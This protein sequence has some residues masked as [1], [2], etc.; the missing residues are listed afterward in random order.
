MVLDRQIRF[1]CFEMVPCWAPSG[2]CVST[3]VR[4][5][6]EGA[7]RFCPKNR[8]S[9]ACIECVLPLV[10]IHPTTHG[11]GFRPICRQLVWTDA[12]LFACPFRSGEEPWLNCLPHIF[13]RLTDPRRRFTWA[14]KVGRN[15]V[16]TKS[17]P[18]QCQV[19]SSP[20]G[21]LEEATAAN[22]TATKQHGCNMP[23]QLQ[24]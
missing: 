17:Q 21:W 24:L 3:I 6:R 18:Q 4:R 8:R 15:I 12:A 10:E 5:G 13:L 1:S 2:K 11:C 14:C 16:P 23:S 7:T 22:A 19:M 9:L 20:L